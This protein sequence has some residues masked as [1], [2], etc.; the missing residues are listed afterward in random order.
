MAEHDLFVTEKEFVELIASA[1]DDGFRI[2][3]NK[4]LPTPAPEYCAT[5][6]EIEQAVKQGQYAFLLERDDFTRY[7]VKVRQVVVNGKEFW[8]P[9]SKEGGPVIEAFYWAPFQ[10]DGQTY[11]PCSLFASHTKIVTPGDRS[12][13]PSGSAVVR[14][15]QAL[16]A[17]MQAA[18]QRVKSHRKSAYVSPGIQE[19]LAAGAKLAEPFTECPI[20]AG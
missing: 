12:H 19:A 2:Q 7:P 9:R 20:S 5:R 18:S 10:R 13:E 6:A 16:V 4:N 1:L 17:S 3:L 14:A 8:Y 11:V 15:L